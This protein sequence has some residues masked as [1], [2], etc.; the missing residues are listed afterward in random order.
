MNIEYKNENLFPGHLGYFFVVLSFGAALLGFI[1]Y[2]IYTRNNQDKSWRTLARSAFI[3]HGLSVIGIFTTL[4][5]LI[6]SH[7]FQYGY[8]WE[9]S[10]RDLPVQY[11][12]SC[13]WEGQEGSF[14]LWT[15]W[16][17]VIGF[18][19]IRTAKSWEGPVMLTLCLVQVM[20]ASMLLGFDNINFFGH[21]FKIGSNPFI[22]LRQKFPNIPLFQ[23]ADYMSMLKDGRGLNAL[24]QNY[25]MV[26]HPPVLFLG[27]AST[28]VPFS[29]AM[30]SLFN[31]RYNEWIRPA[32]PWA[33]FG[34]M[35]LGTGILMG[36]AW[37]YEALS[38]GGFWAWDPVENA[39]LV[40]WL[41]FMA[42]LH[43]MMIFRA[44]KSS[45]GASYIFMILA[46]LL[47]LYSTFL[48]RSGILGDTSVHSFTDLGLSGQLLIF[49]FMFI[50][51]AIVF[52]AW[53]WKWIPKTEKEESTWSREFWMFIGSL[54]LSL[55]ALHIIAITS[56]P[57]FNK[58]SGLIN[59]IL[60]TQLKTNVAKPSD[61]A[62]TYHLLEIPFAIIVAALT[63]VGQ[64]LRYHN[65]KAKKQFWIKIGI[66]AGAAVVL[67]GALA[68]QNDLYY[69][70]YI[71]LLWS[72]FFAVAGNADIVWDFLKQ[73]NLKLSGAAIAHIGFGLILAGALIS[74]AKKQVI[75]IN[76]S[77]M[78]ALPD[79]SPKEQMENKMLIKDFPVGMGGYKVTFLSDSSDDHHIYFR[80]NY[81]RFDKESNK[82]KEEFDLYPFFT[83]SKEKPDQLTPSPSTKHYLT[84]DIFTHITAASDKNQPE[85]KVKYD[86]SYTF[87]IS[88]GQSINL[89]SFALHVDDITSHTDHNGNTDNYTVTA[90]IKAS[91]GWFTYYAKPSF[92]L[93][94]NKMLF[95]DADINEFGLKFHFGLLDPSRTRPQLLILRGH[96]PP[97]Q[98]IALKAM[99]FP[100]INL[101]WLGS[102]IMIIGFMI[103]IFRRAGEYK[104]I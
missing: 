66:S 43:T 4:F 61:V 2:W 17:F 99:V 101:L 6:H 76:T 39:S 73:R 60:H 71:L 93:E 70:E 1:A 68:Y 89:D 10:S 33:V 13:F 42:G 45:L 29:F 16:H 55:S 92:K 100:Y 18:I 72:A 32:M 14:L 74:N 11:M 82:L 47:I 12:I 102:I 15:F 59:D 91:D 40:P 30:A 3:V 5:Y 97:P 96:R 36:G 26:I 56:I 85:F 52:L 53:R 38:F 104:T 46:F 78:E 98:F 35:V 87:D 103:S 7:Q 19:L 75:S 90:V 67:A 21:I 22:L 77:K 69:W 20:L 88:K 24:L 9:H 62:G 48:T 83:T 84:E 37:A 65:T 94:G 25:W 95:E 50:L 63:C 80:V 81:K 8:V 44:R 27:F 49:L 57:V 64:F 31:K 86:T 54:I 28:V 58:I 51:L 34:G 41:V 79:A 23:N